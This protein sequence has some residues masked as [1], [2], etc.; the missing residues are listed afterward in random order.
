MDDKLRIMHLYLAIAGGMFIV[1]VGLVSLVRFHHLPVLS[2]AV[3]PL[4]SAAA[5]TTLREMKRARRRL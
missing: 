1:A 3:G 5:W 4:I 2:F